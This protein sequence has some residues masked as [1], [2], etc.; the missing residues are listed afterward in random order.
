MKKTLVML[1]AAI[2]LP[3]TAFSA[4]N[5]PAAQGITTL[6]SHHAKMGMKMPGGSVPKTADCLMC[7]GGSYAA[8][9]KSTEKV[10]PNPHFNHFGDRNCDTCHRWKEE[11]V[12]SCDEC[13]KFTTLKMPLAVKK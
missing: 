3:V 11:P 8:L 12:L 4:G 9:A 7:H 1:A 10:H 2:L 5:A 6:E 13:H